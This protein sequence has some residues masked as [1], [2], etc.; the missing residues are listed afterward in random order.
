MMKLSDTPMPVIR[1]KFDFYPT[2][3][4]Q[5]QSPTCTDMLMQLHMWLHMCD[6][7]SLL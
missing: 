6:T 7:L 5:L 2:D 1:P 3:T 4:E